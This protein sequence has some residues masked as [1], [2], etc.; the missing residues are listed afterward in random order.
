VPALGCNPVVNSI[1][2]PALGGFQAV[3]R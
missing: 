1:R 2:V 3:G